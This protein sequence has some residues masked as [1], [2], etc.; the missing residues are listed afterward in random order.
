MREFIGER[1]D[2]MRERVESGCGGNFRRN[3]NCQQRVNERGVGNEVRADDAFFQFIRLVQ[4]NGDWRNFAA[5]SCRSRQ[6]NQ[7]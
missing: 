2:A 5:S 3:G 7:K 4:Q 1:L 6:T